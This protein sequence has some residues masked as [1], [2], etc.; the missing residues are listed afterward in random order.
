MLKKTD[1]HLLPWP[2]HRW[3]Q[4]LPD[5]RLEALSSLFDTPQTWEHHRTFYEAAIAVVTDQLPGD[6][7]E[8]LR[9]QVQGL[10]PEPL[11]P[12]IRVTLQEMTPGQFA[13]VHS[14]RPLLGFETHRLIVQLTPDWRPGDGGEFLLYNHPGRPAVLQVPPLRGT[15]VLFPLHSFCLHAVAPTHVRRRTA[16][17]H[18][19]HAG[20]SEDL[21]SAL[22]ALFAPLSFADLPESLDSAIARAEQEAPEE[23]SFRACAVA[24]VLDRWGCPS[25]MLQEGFATALRGC[26]PDHSP[27]PVLLAAWAT[28]LAYDAMDMSRWARLAEILRDR[29]ETCPDAEVLRTLAFPAP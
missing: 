13:E 28:R 8:A 6:W 11:S 4:A 17:F 10:T 23:D 26:P 7:L 25:P 20:N 12:R 14:D 22:R 9:Q 27:T 29:P 18:F 19:H 2:H 1:R 3:E 24:W 15:G 5:V 21:A 16:V